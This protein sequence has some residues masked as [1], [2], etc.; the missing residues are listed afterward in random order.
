MHNQQSPVNRL[1]H[2]FAE[3]GTSNRTTLTLPHCR[4]QPRTAQESLQRHAREASAHHTKE[5]CNPCCEHPCFGFSTSTLPKIWPAPAHRM[6]IGPLSAQ[7]R[8]WTSSDR[9][10]AH[11][12]IEWSQPACLLGLP[13]VR[14]TQSFL[15]EGR[16][17]RP[18]V[19]SAMPPC[20]LVL[21]FL[22]SRSA[23]WS[24]C[25]HLVM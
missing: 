7:R 4:L 13:C 10:C 6:L 16:K 20:L 1:I 5:M 17:S 15:S 25:V 19:A 22:Q 23:L 2:N 9:E 12:K 11:R 18:Q 3:K 21:F 8:C 24:E 14:R